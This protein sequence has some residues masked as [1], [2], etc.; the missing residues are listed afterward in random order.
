MK[1]S[2]RTNQRCPKCG[3]R[4][5]KTIAQDKGREELSMICPSCRTR[6]VTFFVS[7]Y[8]PKELEPDPEKRK[9]RIYRGPSGHPL[10]S[11]AEANRLLEQIRRENDERIFLPDN[12]KPKEID[13]F[14]GNRLFPRWLET[15]QDK[16]PL[17][18]RELKRYCGL[19][20][21]PFFK[22]LDMRKINGG[23]VE[24][25]YLWIGRRQ[26]QLGRQDLSLK[27]KKNI[28]TALAAFCRWLER[29]GTINRLPAFPQVSPPRPPIEWITKEDQLKILEK[30][31]PRHQSIFQFLMTYPVRPGEGRA[32]KVKDLDFERKSIHVCRA[33]SG[34][35]IRSRKNGR[36]YYLP[37]LDGFDRSL[38]KDKHPEAWLFLT[39]RGKP[40]SHWYLDKLWR[41]AF[42]DS[43]FRYISLKNATRHSIASQAWSR[44]VRMEAIS[45][46]LGHTDTKITRER[47][48]SIEV[49]SLRSVIEVEVLE[50]RKKNK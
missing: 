3:A 35:E 27:T 40:Y 13:A 8:L 5:R 44:G 38:V 42:K 26:E 31:P 32:L 30:I 28:M 1:G 6:P 37:L 23:H 2:V 50:M 33:L 19:Y 47:Y 36:D 10:S 48:A 16:S 34:G 43:G 25:F 7:I 11:Y 29:R 18:F 39:S 45:A 46:A 24:D 17:H 9:L 20:F 21:V 15:K 12:Y 41:E 22:H 14:R 4:F 49:E